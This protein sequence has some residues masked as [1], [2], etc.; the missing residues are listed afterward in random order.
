MVIESGSVTKR[1]NERRMDMMEPLYSRSNKACQ[2]KK[3]Q[4]LQR[5][6]VWLKK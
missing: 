3:Q 2:D 6:D 1:R 5:I 4:H